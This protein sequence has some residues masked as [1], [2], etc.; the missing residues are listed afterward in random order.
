M[1]SDT[2]ELAAELA[3]RLELWELKSGEEIDEDA[4]NEEWTKWLT[5]RVCMKV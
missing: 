3:V 4:M 2:G 5:M 1:S